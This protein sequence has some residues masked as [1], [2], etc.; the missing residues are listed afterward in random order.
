MY[1]KSLLNKNLNKNLTIYETE[2]KNQQESGT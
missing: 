2:R 1:I